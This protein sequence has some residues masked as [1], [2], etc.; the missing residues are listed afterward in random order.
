MTL[1]SARTIEAIALSP[2]IE[3]GDV[4][5]NLRR[6][7]DAL[8]GFH[9]DAPRLVVAPELATSGYVFTD[10]D[11]AMRL[12]M[13]RDDDRLSR[14][15]ERLGS[16]TVAV[17]GFAELDGDHLYNSAA[18]L[19]RDGVLAVY[20]KSHLWGEEKLV[21]TPGTDAG[22]VVDTSVGLLGVAICY[23]NEFP[24]VPRA[25]ALSGADLLALPVNWPLVPR[26]EGERPPETIQ[27]MGAARSSRLPTVIAD[28][29]GVERGVEWTG[30]TAVIDGEGWVVAEDSDGAATAILQITTG[31]KGLGPHNDLFA[32]RRPDIYRAHSS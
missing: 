32:D 6:L 23:D 31:D 27:A 16:Q 13:P 1:S 7:A 17:I 24:E 3:V 18:V 29:H 19:T 10:R 15:A 5:A 28:R 8:S 9:D 2:M 12:A 11:E 21:F 20:R 14:L 30:G 22:M 25:L 4:D 26:P